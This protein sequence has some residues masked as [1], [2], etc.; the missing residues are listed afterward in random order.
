[1]V[2]KKRY[3]SQAEEDKR[4]LQFIENRK[5]VDKHYGLLRINEYSDLSTQEAINVRTG[6]IIPE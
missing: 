3:A 5:F 4:K 6:L 1:M 2:Y